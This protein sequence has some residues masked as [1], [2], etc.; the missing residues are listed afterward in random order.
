MGIPIWKGAHMST[1][2][3]PI[4]G[5]DFIAIPTRDYEAA[6]KFYGE[7]LGLP[8]GKQWGEMPAGEFETGTVTLAVMQSDAFGI[9]FA[10]HTHPVEFHVDDFEA[11]K[12]ELESRGIE[13][14]DVIDSG[15]CWQSIFRDPDGNVLAIHHRYAP[16]AA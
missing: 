11:A 3:Q 14:G 1:T 13:F 6:R 5:V 4:S 9:E 2:T 8:F 12:A 15:V 10:P 16:Q 7:V